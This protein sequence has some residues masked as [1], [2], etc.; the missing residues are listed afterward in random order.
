MCFAILL[1]MN[2]TDSCAISEI[3]LT[4]N[5]LEQVLFVP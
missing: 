2:Y 3:F 1:I 5:E 4:D